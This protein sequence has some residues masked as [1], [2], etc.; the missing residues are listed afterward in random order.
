MSVINK[1]KKELESIFSVKVLAGVLRDLSVERVQNLREDFKKNVEFYEEIEDLFGKVQT[2]INQQYVTIAN[3][4]RK[5]PTA[6]IVIT[7]N[8]RFYGTLNQEV[9]DFFL[10]EWNKAEDHIVVGKMGQVYLENHD[11]YDKCKFMFFEEDNPTRWEMQ[12]FV[13]LAKGYSQAVIYFPKYKTPFHQEPTKMDIIRLA[14][15]SE[16][17]F[18]DLNEF[19]FEPDLPLIHDFFSTQVQYILIQRIM[20]ETDLS[21]TAMRLVRMD[22]AENSAI[23]M[24]SQKNRELR[25][26]IKKELD[27]Q[28]FESLSGLQKWK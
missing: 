19:I 25:D 10:E 13:S 8:H 22:N 20:L 28:L 27:I 12:K 1:T 18:S 24:Y 11:F 16:R 7:S 2:L 6:N 15:K 17:D 5:R 21:R 23:E 14:E 9:T 4:M 26:S 3:E